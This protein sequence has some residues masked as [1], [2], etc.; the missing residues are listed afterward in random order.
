MLAVVNNQVVD[1]AIPTNMTRIQEPPCSTSLELTSQWG[2][3][4]FW[5]YLLLPQSLP[6]LHQVQKDVLIVKSMAF[7]SGNQSIYPGQGC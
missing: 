5:R 3:G 1:Q 6:Y 7:I 4:I 2:H